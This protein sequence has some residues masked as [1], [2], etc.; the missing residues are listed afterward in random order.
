ME[1][2]E[3]YRKINGNYDTVYACFHS[4]KQ[5]LKF[6]LKFLD[7]KSYAN[8][9]NSLNKEDYEAAFLAA[10]SLKGICQNLGFSELFT[11]SERITEALRGG[12]KSENLDNMFYDVTDKYNKTVE[13]ILELKESIE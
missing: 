9:L 5:I 4:D 1:I 10:H 8:L 3:C 13:A 11:V 7:E 12:K 6:L 2:R